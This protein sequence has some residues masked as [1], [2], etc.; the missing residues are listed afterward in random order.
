MADFS[1]SRPHAQETLPRNPKRR[2]SLSVDLDP[3]SAY[4]R[5][6][7]LAPPDHELT[8]RVVER[9]WR[10]FL[11]L[12]RDLDLSATFFVVGETLTKE[13]SLLARRATEEGHELA[14]HTWHHPYGFLSLAHEDMKREI[15][16]G[17]EAIEEAAGVCPVGFRCPGYGASKGHLRLLDDLG[18]RYDSSLLPSPPYY[19]AKAAVMGLLR[20]Q[21]KNSGAKLHPIR[22]VLGPTTPY[23]VAP[24]T[25]WAPYHDP[26]P[27]VPG[28]RLR[29][30]P[31][32]VTPGARI[33]IIGTTLSLA[34]PPLTWYLRWGARRQEFLNFECHAIDLVDATRD[35]LPKALVKK[36]PDL[37]VPLDEKKRRLEAFLRELKSTHEF[38][39]L[40]SL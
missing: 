22:S 10:R 31:I 33:P 9:G 17:G 5:I 20:L 23:P 39:R 1:G 37:Q 25:P 19:L 40:D 18:Y 3:L 30:L 29:E 35:E 4:C 24:E 11:D 6:H 7:G 13:A 2:A 21:G 8:G 38:C 26:D 32:S 28:S 15:Q 16:G 27:A 34:R 36:Q 12:A 14:N